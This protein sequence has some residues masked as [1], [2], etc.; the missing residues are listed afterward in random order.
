MKN[1]FERY[2]HQIT[3]LNTKRLNKRFR[4][5]MLIFFPYYYISEYIR[6]VFFWNVILEEL[7]QNQE[8]IDYLDKNEFGIKNRMIYKKDLI[9]PDSDLYGFKLDK[10][11]EMISNEYAVQITNLIEKKSSFNVEDYIGFDV[12]LY[13]YRDVEG[14]EPYRIYEVYLMYYRRPFFQIMKRK[15]MWWCITFGVIIM[16]AFAL[17]F[18]FFKK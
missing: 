3:R 16:V 7:D 8:L 13:N 2:S 18:M 5:W 12:N 11:K 10:L 14:K 1:N 9:L 17:Y 15:L 4:I 6:Q